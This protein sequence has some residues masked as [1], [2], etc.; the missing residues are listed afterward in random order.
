MIMDSAVICSKFL[1]FFEKRGHKTVKSSSLL[2]DDQSVLLTTAGMQQFKPYYVNPGI[3]DK[4]LGSRKACSIQKCFRTSDLD[5]VG[6]ETHLTFFEMLGNFSFGDYFKEEAI[7]LAIEFLEKEMKIPFQKMVFA[8]FK[9]DKEVPADKES[10]E[11]FKATGAKKVMKASRADNFW[12]PTGEEGPCG[13]TAEIYV[14]DVEL[15]NLVFNEYYM[16][17][18]KKLTPLKFKGVDTGMGIER[19]AMVIQN[20]KNVFETDLFEL[21]MKRIDSFSN[22]KIDTVTKRIIADHSKGTVFLINDGVRPSNIE[23]GYILRRIMRRIIRYARLFNFKKE[24]FSE[25]V[26]TIINIYKNRYP[27]LEKNKTEIIKVIE[28]EKKRFEC[29]LDKGLREFDKITK[30]KKSISGKEAF[31]LY[32]SYGFPLE[33]TKDLAKEKRIKVDEKGFES[34]LRKHQKLSRAGAEKK[35]GG[36]GGFGEKV[37][38]QHTATHLLHAALRKILGE[39]VQQAGSDLTPERLRFDFIHPKKLTEEEKKKV[40]DLVNKKIKE[41]IP[42]KCGEM[43]Y[44]EAIKSGALCFFKEK[45]PERVTVYSIGDFSKEICAGPHVKNTK[46]IG[47]FRIKNE[48][49]SA[50][51]IRR[52]KAVVG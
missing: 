38:K 23:E 4:D 12:G 3:A 15:W 30:S 49:S 20:K 36:A 26:E 10:E 22:K 48:E 31:L 45:Y 9:G 14:N 19:L 28:E 33:I 25:M 11:I 44:E 16:H 21:L 18:N 52:I 37:A 34:E 29:S 2:P 5:E 27:E 42:V 41:A 7:K 35:F 43:G 6:D 24:Y 51:G 13:P 47:S 50:A 40:E 39:H 46:E 17:R 1:K 8:V 32:Q